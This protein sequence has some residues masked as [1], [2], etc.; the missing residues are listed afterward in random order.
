MPSPFQNEMKM[1]PWVPNAMFYPKVHEFLEKID[2][3]LVIQNGT[4]VLE[5]LQ[6]KFPQKWPNKFKKTW[7]KIPWST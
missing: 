4:N 2:F 1:V 6:G 5:I 7:K 3:P